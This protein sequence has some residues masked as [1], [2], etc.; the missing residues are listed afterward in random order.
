MH[1]AQRAAVANQPKQAVALFREAAARDLLDPLPLKAA[2]FLEYRLAQLDPRL[3]CDNEF[4]RPYIE[5]G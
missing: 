5:A 1:Q 3:R 4:L 2:A